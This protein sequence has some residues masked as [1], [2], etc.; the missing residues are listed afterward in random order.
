ML[1]CV[2]F[3]FSTLYCFPSLVHINLKEKMH[4]LKNPTAQEIDQNVNGICNM[5]DFLPP[6]LYLKFFLILFLQGKVYIT[7]RENNYFESKVLP[8]VNYWKVFLRTL[9]SVSQ[10]CHQK[11]FPIKVSKFNWKVL[12]ENHQ[13]QQNI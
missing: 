1:G 10:V 13:L 3:S 8:P 9:D 4:I 11:Y 12:R 7:K 2:I 5:S 6:L